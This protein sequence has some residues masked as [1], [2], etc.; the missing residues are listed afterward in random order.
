MGRFQGEDD[1]QAIQ[2]S[3]IIVLLVFQNHGVDDEC[4]SYILTKYHLFVVRVIGI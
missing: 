1:Q 3:R 4:R 2:H